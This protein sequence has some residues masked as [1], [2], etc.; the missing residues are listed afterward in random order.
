MVFSV[1]GVILGLLFSGKESDSNARKVGK[2]GKKR[3]Y[4][5][6]WVRLEMIFEVSMCVSYVYQTGMCVSSRERRR[7]I[8]FQ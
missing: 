6:K 2:K 5:E 1:I 3:K 4:I 8:K 7:K